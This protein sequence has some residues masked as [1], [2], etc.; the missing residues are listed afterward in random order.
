ML[1]WWKIPEMRILRAPMTC[2][3]LIS[4]VVSGLHPYDI[5]SLL[6]KKDIAV[7]AGSHCVQPTF[8]GVGI[9]MTV[10]V[11]PVFYNMIEEID[12]F[13]RVLVK[14]IDM[15]KKWSPRV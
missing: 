7:C 1:C 12:D 14:T 6:D 8:A 13:I 11:S 10:R 2:V 9:D 15:L 5:A 4:F 3:S